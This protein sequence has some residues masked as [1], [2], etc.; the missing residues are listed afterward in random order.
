MHEVRGDD[1]VSRQS[2]SNEHSNREHSHHPHGHSNAEQTRSLTITQSI[3][4]KNDRL[5]ERN[6]GYF[7]AKGLLVLN[8]LKAKAAREF[9]NRFR[10]I[11]KLNFVTPVSLCSSQQRNTKFLVCL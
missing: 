3:L 9:I 10:G 11:G 8:T 1:G 5:A 2:I 7:L 4:S 6:R